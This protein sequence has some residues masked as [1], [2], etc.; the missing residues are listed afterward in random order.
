M[1]L[2]RLDCH[3]GILALFMAMS[4]RHCLLDNQSLIFVQEFFTDCWLY[5]F[6]FLN[7]CVLKRNYNYHFAGKKKGK[8]FVF[9][10]L[11]SCLAARQKSGWES[12]KAVGKGYPSV[13]GVLGDGGL[14]VLTVL[15]TLVAPI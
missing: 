5:F 7:N 3:S 10:F 1:L 4:V 13:S 11:C 15:E 2:A 12:Q 6:F 8:T 9:I 14:F